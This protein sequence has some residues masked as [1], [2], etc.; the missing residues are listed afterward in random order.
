MAPSPLG[1]YAFLHRI[2]TSGARNRS[3]LNYKSGEHAKL[4]LQK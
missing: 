2:N 3:L 1:H 4:I